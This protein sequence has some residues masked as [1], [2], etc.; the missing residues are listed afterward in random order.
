MEFE[1][2]FQVDNVKKNTLYIYSKIN[3]QLHVTVLKQGLTETDLVFK[4]PGLKETD[5]V[6]LKKIKVLER[7]TLT[8]L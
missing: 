4:K 5:T 3:K 7:L 2:Y 1:V 8:V 6:C